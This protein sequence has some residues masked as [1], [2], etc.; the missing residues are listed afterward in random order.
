[1][2]GVYVRRLPGRRLP[3]GVY[4]GPVVP[5]ADRGVYAAVWRHLPR[6]ARLRQRQ[7]AYGHTKTRVRA[8]QNPRTG[9]PEPTYGHT[10]THGRAR[11]SPR[12]C[13]P[14]PAYEHTKTRV[15]AHQNPRTGL[16][17]PG[18]DPGVSVHAPREHVAG[19]VEDLL[20]LRPR[21]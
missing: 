1:A 14:K 12:T 9:T 13:T 4:H 5:A 7:P 3:A 10:R 6:F 17:W 8:H 21:V 11:R 2:G 15:R 19:V 20:V 16:G 18:P